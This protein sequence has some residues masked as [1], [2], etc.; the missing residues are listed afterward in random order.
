MY[1]SNQLTKDLALE[2][3]K[4]GKYIK[5]SELDL[6]LHNYVE[7]VKA[8][9]WPMIKMPKSYA[10]IKAIK[11]AHARMVAELKEFDRIHGQNLR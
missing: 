5:H 3:L 11:A 4:R 6:F 8:S 7:P 9:T 2:E 1:I 10:Q